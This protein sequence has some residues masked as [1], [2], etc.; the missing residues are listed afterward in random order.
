[1]TM[2]STS[3]PR[4]VLLTGATGLVG[5]RLVRRLLD[6]DPASTV[7]ALVRPQSPRTRLTEAAGARHVRV[8]AITGD[9][10]APGLGL[11]TATRRRLRRA[12]RTIVHCAADTSFSRPLDTARAVNT[13][14]TLHALDLADELRVERFVHVSTAFVAGC[15]TG[16]IAE[17]AHDGE[18]G[19]VNGYEQSKHEAERLVFDADL[20]WSIVRPS[21]IVCDDAS[22]GVS[23]I[24]AVHR[25]LRV[26]HAGLAALMP[27]GEDTPVD[28]VTAEH[29]VRAVAAAVF[30]D[31]AVG[32][33]HHACAGTGALPLGELLDRCDAVWRR[34]AEWRRR[35]IARPA[36]TD[37]ET[38]RLFEASVEETGDVRL[39]TITRSLSHFVPQLA[40]PKHF[41][42]ANADALTG[43]AAPRVADF[44]E[45]MLN[46]LHASRWGAAGRRAA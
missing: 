6:E 10:S 43:V 31:A 7:Y 21:T 36:L 34:D 41:V 2:R 1:M 16:I 18:V 35:A 27:G 30:S 44:W 20:A 19:F 9:V 45:P 8:H 46:A 17:R 12:V 38:Y 42:T 26:F 3:A 24:N 15:M 32:R 40:L 11:D 28:V 14:G 4:A 23:Q 33:I 5:T 37:L 29:V 13:A 25:A 39:A 22:G